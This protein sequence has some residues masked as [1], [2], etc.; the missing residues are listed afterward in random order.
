[1]FKFTWFLILKP[2]FFRFRVGAV[3]MTL[4]FNLLKSSQSAMIT[5]NLIMLSILLI[6]LDYIMHYSK[7]SETSAY[8]PPHMTSM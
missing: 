3:T 2:A 7:E 6:K 5:H 8:F 4:S 1:M